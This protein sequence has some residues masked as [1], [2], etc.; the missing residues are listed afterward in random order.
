M[1]D[2]E[3]EEQEYYW[4][5][6][7]EERRIDKKIMDYKLDLLA[8]VMREEINKIKSLTKVKE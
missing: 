3:M 5:L 1:F 4:N 8:E 7:R 6:W 2:I